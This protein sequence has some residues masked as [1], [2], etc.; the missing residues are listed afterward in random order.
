[1]ILREKCP[2]LEFFWSYFPEFGL[3]KGSYGPEKLRIQT[4]FTQ[5]ELS[6]IVTVDTANEY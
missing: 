4:L 2:Y 3:N 6:K 5:C 1:M